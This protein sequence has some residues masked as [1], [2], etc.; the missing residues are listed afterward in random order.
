MPF[1]V[2]YY[3][4]LK[5]CR[6]SFYSYLN[7]K[8]IFEGNNKICENSVVSSSYLGFASYLG[9]NCSLGNC[10]IGRYC[11]IGSNVKL[12]SSLHPTSIFVSTHPAFFSKAKQ[13]GFT[14]VD[15]NLFDEHK[16]VD[17]KKHISVIIGN[18][19]WIGNNVTILG[20]IRINDG[21][22]IATG[23]VVSKDVKPFE[24][25]GGVPA[26]HIKF[27]F[28]SEEIFFLNKIKWWNKSENWIRE[29]VDL[30]K[31]ISLFIQKI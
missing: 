22:I 4:I 18:D 24:I 30:F 19:V 25:V 11:S 23:A 12:I 9:A 7:S 3:R 15:K 5:K 20:G 29:N 21:A 2:I 28:N 27:R 10:I 26:K 6:V 13:A 8:T 16:Y 31:D 14:Y 17:R 1:V